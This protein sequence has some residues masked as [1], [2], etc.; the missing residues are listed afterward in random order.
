[1]ETRILSA[2]HRELLKTKK[3]KINETVNDFNLTFTLIAIELGI[4]EEDLG[5]WE[6]S[7]IGHRFEKKETKELP[8][9]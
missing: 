9:V 4:A 7:S 3:E 5:Q 8:H 6:L 1:M 2:S